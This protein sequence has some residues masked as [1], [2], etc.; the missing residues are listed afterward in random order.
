MVLHQQF[1]KSLIKE[2]EES[3]QGAIGSR[4]ERIDKI[5]QLNFPITTLLSLRVGE[6]KIDYF[7]SGL[8]SGSDKK[9]FSF[10]E[11]GCYSFLVFL[12]LHAC[13]QDQIL[14]KIVGVG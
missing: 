8:I 3:D 10:P 1:F 7:F 13:G 14:R 4:V 2:A 5:A 9:A 6:A 11:G 12:P